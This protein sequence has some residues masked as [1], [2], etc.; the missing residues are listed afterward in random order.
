MR[1]FLHHTSHR[2]GVRTLNDLVELC[3]SET[4][5]NLLVRFRRR[6]GRSIPLDFDLRLTLFRFS[7]GLCHR[8]LLPALR[9]SHHYA[10]CASSTNCLRNRATAAGSFKLLNPSKVARTT[11]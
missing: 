8:T 6:D 2:P 7:P 10:D 9:R 1:D 11:L 5:H 4:A 3:K